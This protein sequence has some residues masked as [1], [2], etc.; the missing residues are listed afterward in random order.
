L[1]ILCLRQD[2]MRQATTYVAE[3]RALC[4]RLSPEHLRVLREPNFELRA[5]Y[6]F[7]RGGDGSRPWSGPVPLIRG[8]AWAPRIAFDLA[9]G[10]RGKTPGADEAIRALRAVA[11]EPGVSEAVKLA[12]GDLLVLNNRSC[13]HARNT[14]EA[15]FDGRDRWLHRVYVRRSLEGLQDAPTTSW[16]VL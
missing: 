3:A 1:L 10:L 6:S 4:E 14:F 16:R 15:K 12:P 9:C 8:P 13:A 2:P 5:P 11:R 7:T